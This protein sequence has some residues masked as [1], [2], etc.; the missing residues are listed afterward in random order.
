MRLPHE[1]RSLLVMVHGPATDAPELLI[2]A[3]SFLKLMMLEEKGC[4]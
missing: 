2:D 1:Q 4:A 3:Q